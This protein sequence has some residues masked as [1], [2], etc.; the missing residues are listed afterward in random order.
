MENLYF[1]VALV[2]RRYFYLTSQ[3]FDDELES[4]IA[5][6]TKGLKVQL[7]SKIS[8]GSYSY[9]IF[10]FSNVLDGVQHKRIPQWSSF[11]IMSFHY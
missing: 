3:Q 4:Q 11:V 1:H 7:E 6:L 10:G 8:E 9:V 2:Y 5:K